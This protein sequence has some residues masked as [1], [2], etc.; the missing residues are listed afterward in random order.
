L[1]INLPLR[2]VCRSLNL[3]LI[4]LGAIAALQLI[5]NLVLL[6]HTNTKKMAVTV[7][8]GPEAE[9]NELQL[10]TEMLSRQKE[11][12]TAPPTTGLSSG[13]E[14]LSSKSEDLSYHVY[15]F[16]ENVHMDRPG[17][18]AS[19]AKSSHGTT[20]NKTAYAGA[21]GAAKRDTENAIIDS[22]IQMSA[23]PGAGAGINQDE[24]DR[25][26]KQ[27]HAPLA[28]STHKP[29]AYSTYQINMEIAMAE[30]LQAAKAV[31]FKPGTVVSPPKA[32][33][34]AAGPSSVSDED[35]ARALAE[36]ELLL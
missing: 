5:L 35:L 36:S 9:D 10:A 4:T 1:V 3:I 12:P 14:K 7:V 21:S 25:R 15:A 24:V 32:T 13:S 17:T 26:Q 22:Y 20:A 34:A 11:G 16:S 23:F 2:C 18:I 6:C 19:P 27:E 33:G 31:Q 28:A 30:S 29:T 8:D